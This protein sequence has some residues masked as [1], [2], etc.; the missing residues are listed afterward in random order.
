MVCG[1]TKGLVLNI[2]L[3][4]LHSV[5]QG[6][7][8]KFGQIV[9]GIFDENRDQKIDFEEFVMALNVITHGTREEKLNCKM[10]LISCT[11][12]RAW[13]NYN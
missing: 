5:V 11:I 10:F 6:D 4:L 8:V 1:G 2:A 13:A 12:I 7:G 3:I 9:F